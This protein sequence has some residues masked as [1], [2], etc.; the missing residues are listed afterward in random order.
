MT[1]KES[2]LTEVDMENSFRDDA[3]KPCRKETSEKEDVAGDKTRNE[4]PRQQVEVNENRAL[5]GTP[6]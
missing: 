5:F 2:A 1:L 6:S 3:W 4:A